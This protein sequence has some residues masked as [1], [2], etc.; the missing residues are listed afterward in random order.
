MSLFDQYG[1]ELPRM[2]R[3]LGFSDRPPVPDRTEIGAVSSTGINPK[4]PQ[5]RESGRRNWWRDVVAEGAP[6]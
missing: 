1:R 5:W 3:P 6:E 4:G 2:R